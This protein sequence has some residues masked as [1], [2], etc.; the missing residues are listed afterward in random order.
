M[1]YL[2]PLLLLASLLGC[3]AETKG[4]RFYS[5][6]ALAEPTTQN[7]SD[8]KIGIG[9]VYIPRTLKRPQI[10]TRKN[11][12]EL[13][14]AEEHQWGGSLREDIIQVLGEN[15]SLQLGTQQ[16]EAFPWKQSFRPDYQIRIHIEQLDG[17]LG[18]NVT[19]KARWRLIK[20]T[21]VQKAEH[22]Q[23]VIPVNGQ[24]YNAYVQAQSE[25]LHRLSQVIAAQIKH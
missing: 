25:A 12:T 20:Q 21:Q 2:F 15:L 7:L 4:T 13:A 1:K 10:V 5:L 8:L 18:K 24:D 9:P 16:I 22:S 17:E 3:S 6:T 19:L 14:L 11:Q 23:M